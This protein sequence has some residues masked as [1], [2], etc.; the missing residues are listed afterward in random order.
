M[1]CVGIGEG[2]GF[3]QLDVSC[4]IAFPHRYILLNR[5]CTSSIDAAVATVIVIPCT[6]IVQIIAINVDHPKHFF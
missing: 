5:L 2:I 4:D 3:Q 6:I 1:R